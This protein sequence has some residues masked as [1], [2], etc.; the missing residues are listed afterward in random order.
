MSVQWALLAGMVGNVS[1]VGPTCRYG[2]QPRVFDVPTS[3]LL[4][5]FVYHSFCC[6]N[7][8]YHFDMTKPALLENHEDGKL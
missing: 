6:L 2:G 5:T 8:R 3:Q 1:P 7:C 4:C